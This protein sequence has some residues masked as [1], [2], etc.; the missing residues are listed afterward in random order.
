MLHSGTK[1]LG[2]HSD[3]L[4]GLVTCSPTNIDL[5][6]RIRQAQVL[7]GAVAS[8][9]DCWLTLRGLRTLHLRMDRA[10]DN[11]LSV[12]T[13]LDSHPSVQ[14]VFYPGLPTHPQHNIAK[15]Q[16]NGK[17]GAMLS[18]LMK[19][20]DAAMKVSDNVQL[21]QRATSLG[22]TETLI[23]HRA[24]IE[25]PDRTVTPDTLLRVSVG[26]E[27]ADDIIQDLERSIEA[28]SPPLKC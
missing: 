26:L 8:P 12:A 3:V 7:M 11:A 6:N 15:K 14:E 23:E 4:L 5:N 24:S 22:G 16:M 10:C 21:I 9:L 1:Y 25:P 28:A 18:F 20:K 17:Y 13:F 27:D 19:H 2:G